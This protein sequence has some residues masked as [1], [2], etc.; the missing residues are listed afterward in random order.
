MVAELA[1]ARAELPLL[2]SAHITQHIIIYLRCISMSVAL[3]MFSMFNQYMV[4]NDIIP[5][6]SILN[7]IFDAVNKKKSN[8][9]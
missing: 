2:C 4:F 3:I 8:D 5:L 9:I 1:L 6:H 7:G